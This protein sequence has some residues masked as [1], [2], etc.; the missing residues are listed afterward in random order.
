MS[1]RISVVIPTFN[2]GVILDDCIR[3]V[4]ESVSEEDQ[5]IVVNDFK[6]KPLFDKWLD[7]RLEVI[8]NPKSG[9]ASARN[10]GA[11]KAEAPVL[12]FIDDDMLIN[13]KALESC[14]RLLQEKPKSVVMSDWIFNPVETEKMKSSSI[15][16]F[17][18]SRGRTSLRGWSAGLE[19]KENSCVLNKGVTSQFLMMH[20]NFFRSIGGYD[21]SFP[22]AGFEDYD[23]ARK[24]VSREHQQLINTSCLIYHNEKDRIGLIPFLERQKRGAVSRKKAVQRGYSELKIPI[25]LMKHVY[26]RLLLILEPLLGFLI[27]CTPNKKEFDT[28]Y[29]FLVQRMLGISF[30]RGYWHSFK[31]D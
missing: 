6:Q 2:R 8:E 4:L 3:S 13:R 12:L 5:I 14:Y 16:R 1:A 9:V 24:I 7:Y 11:F 26:Y 19:W 27:D 22:F 23:L 29:T 25:P 30:Y 28:I 20:T 15:G 18:I 31:N 10:L 21:E 17:M